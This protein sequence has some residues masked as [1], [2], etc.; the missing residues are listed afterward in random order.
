MSIIV[1]QTIFF[2]SEQA[3]TSPELY[4]QMKEFCRDKGHGFVI[5]K[6]GGSLLFVHI[7]E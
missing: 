6:D 7:S 4:G 5:P 3:R 2:R 1:Y